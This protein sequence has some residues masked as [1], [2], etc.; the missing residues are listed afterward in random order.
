[1]RDLKFRAWDKSVKT[2]CDV[3]E[4]HFCHGGIKAFGPGV[5]LGNGWVT[6][7]NEHKH[8]CDVIVMEYTGLQDKNGKDI[9]EGD[10]ALC[11]I[12]VNVQDDCKEFSYYNRNQDGSRQ[13]VC[14]KPKPA[15]VRFHEDGYYIFEHHTGK[16]CS[17]YLTKGE[18]LEVIGNIYESPE[19]LE[20]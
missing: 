14:C 16:S 19:L 2:M 4:I 7:R 9:Y 8:H 12:S 18:E 13:K 1:M 3:G 20:G 6:E 11:K 17:C 5:N 10:I 15:L